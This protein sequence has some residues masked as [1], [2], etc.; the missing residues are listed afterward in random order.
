MKANGTTPGDFSSS[1]EDIGVVGGIMRVFSVGEKGKKMD[2]KE[3]GNISDADSAQQGELQRQLSGRHLNFIAIGGTIG[4]G[5][6]LGTGTALVKA[7]PAACLISYIFVGSILWSVMVCLGEMATYI[8][9]AGAF[10]S[11]ATR[12]VDS[13][14]GFAVGWLYWFGCESLPPLWCDTVAW[15]LTVRKQGPSPTPYPSSPPAL[16]SNTGNT[17]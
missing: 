13:S 17:T 12:F 9:T 6:F 14:L 11:Y 2:G 1:G 7:G 16:S 4:T 3:K 8:P 10:S 5:F 15:R